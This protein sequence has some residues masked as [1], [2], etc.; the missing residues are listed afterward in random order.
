MRWRGTHAA[1][2]TLPSTKRTRGW[3]ARRTHRCSPQSRLRELWRC[4]SDRYSESTW[5]DCRSCDRAVKGGQKTWR[6][7]NTVSAEGTRRNRQRIGRA[8][9]R[10][11]GDRI[12]MGKRPFGY[13]QFGGEN[14]AATGL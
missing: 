9:R 10:Y 2:F 7:R 6:P 8:S 4:S 13:Q 14:A 12:E 1:H 5:I 11:G 3:Y